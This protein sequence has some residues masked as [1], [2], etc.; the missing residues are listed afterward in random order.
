MI[1]NYKEYSNLL[2]E[3]LIRT[4]DINKYQR[5]LTD[6]IDS[7][8]I[9]Y[10]INIVDKLKFYVELQ[11]NNLNVVES[12]NHQSYTLGYF[13][14]EYKV[15]LLNGMSNKFKELNFN[16]QNISSVEVSYESKYEDGLYTN[17]IICPNKLYHLSKSKNWDSIDKNGLYPKSKNR[18]SVHPERIYLFDD[19]NNYIPLLNRLK[20][21]D[22]INGFNYKYD[23]L[24]IDTSG[25]KLILHTDPNYR[26]GYFTYDNI[27][28]NII[29]RIKNNI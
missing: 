6:Y 2:K 26:F 4:H 16:F 28:P 1:K 12:V 8:N 21:S 7:L 5:I 27:S 20:L 24:E 22:G 3:G 15:T 23:L 19:I 17:N 18:V 14:S 13:P 10:S 9:K 11:T 29:N 25:D